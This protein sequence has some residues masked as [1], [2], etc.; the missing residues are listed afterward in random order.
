MFHDN[1]NE[2][3]P[4]QLIWTIFKVNWFCFNK[5]QV[6][7]ICHLTLF[8]KLV[9]R[10]PFCYAFDV[11]WFKHCQINQNCLLSFTK[12]NEQLVPAV[13]LKKEKFQLLY[14]FK[15]SLSLNA[16]LVTSKSNWHWTPTKIILFL[17]TLI[18]VNILPFS[19]IRYWD[20][21]WK[22]VYLFMGIIISINQRCLFIFTK[23]N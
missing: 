2:N 12:K 17:P 22:N 23:K 3:I 19:L 8:S 11:K 1:R 4:I 15:S 10:K 13:D 21:N 16:L 7:S 6:H 5:T 14:L 18:G 9:W 20:K